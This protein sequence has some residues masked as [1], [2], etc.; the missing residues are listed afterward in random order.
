[1]AVINMTVMQFKPGR[2]EDG[3]ATIKTGNELI[4]KHGG[5]NVAT[6]VTMM[7]GP[8]TGTVSTLWTASDYD[9]YGKIFNAIMNDPEVQA[10]I[11]SSM[12]ADGATVSFHTYVSQTIPDV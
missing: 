10:L 4:K 2:W 3:V 7:G 6:M 8:A 1:M 12:G 9:S 5:E 11:A